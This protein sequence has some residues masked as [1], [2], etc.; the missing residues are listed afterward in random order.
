MIH[1]APWSDQVFNNGYYLVVT[2]I[3]LSHNIYSCDQ[4][5]PINTNDFF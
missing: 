1:V 2:L 5:P 3:T 4:C